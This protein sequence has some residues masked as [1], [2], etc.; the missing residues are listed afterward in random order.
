MAWLTNEW[1]G[2]GNL[3]ADP[4]VKFVG[5]G[6]CLTKFVLGVN[7][8]VN[9]KERTEFIRCQSWGKLAET[10]GQYCGKGDKIDVAGAL[11][12]DKYVN[13]NGETKYYTYI[14]VDRMK[15]VTKKNNKTEKQPP[16]EK[17]AS[18]V[19]S[20]TVEEWTS[21]KSDEIFRPEDTADVPF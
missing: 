1:R 16:E 2:T 3:V 5:D 18:N 13:K 9:G 10:I 8:K 11:R 7:E 19:P 14:N 17:P 15:F 6:Y 12:T 4:D 21:T 20:G